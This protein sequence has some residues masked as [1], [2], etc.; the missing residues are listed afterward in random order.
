MRPVIYGLE[1]HEALANFDEA[2]R[3]TNRLRIVAAEF[4]C[5][6]EERAEPEVGYAGVATCW[7]TMRDAAAGVIKFEDFCEACKKRQPHAEAHEK[8]RKLEQKMYR[9]LC[10]WLD[11][12][13]RTPKRSKPALA[14][15]ALA[16]AA[17][18]YPRI[19]LVARE[20]GYAAALHGTCARDV[21]I[22]FVPWKKGAARVSV[23]V[24]A[25]AEAIGG[26]IEVE[27]EPKEP[28]INKPIQ[29]GYSCVI[30]LGGGPYL[31]CLIIARN[32]DREDL[33]GMLLK[34][35]PHDSTT[36]ATDHGARRQHEASNSGVGISEDNV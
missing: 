15:K 6:S 20:H 24:P 11:A 16:K 10:R 32:Q 22:I 18:L 31:D 19:A 9:R 35:D 7:R 36:Q 12:S 27:G 1:I 8:A 23:F 29:G 4:K 30:H 3:E 26:F 21:D 14:Q 13:E 17:E 33:V 2:R 28:F 5:E 34:K 25:L